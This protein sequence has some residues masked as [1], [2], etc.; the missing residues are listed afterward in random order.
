MVIPLMCTQKCIIL[1]EKNHESMHGGMH[2]LA[3]PPQPLKNKHRLIFFTGTAG[4]I[5]KYINFL[6]G[7][8]RDTTGTT[9]TI[10]KS[11]NF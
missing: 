8:N 6:P 5:L 2:G 7:Q 11:F 4:T 10:L 3:P 1:P 9:G